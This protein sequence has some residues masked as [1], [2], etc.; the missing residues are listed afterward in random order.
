MLVCIFTLH[1]RRSQPLRASVPQSET[2]RVYDIKYYGGLVLFVSN[3]CCSGWEAQSGAV[4][5]RV[6]DLYLVR[7]LCLLSLAESEVLRCG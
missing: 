1:W 7:C 4:G 2:D 5:D 3:A 6:C